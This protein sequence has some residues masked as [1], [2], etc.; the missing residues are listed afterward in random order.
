MTNHKYIVVAGANGDLGA[1]ICRE[2]LARNARV[3]AL[4]RPGANRNELASLKQDALEIFDVDFSSKEQLIA[5]VQ[6]AHCVVSALSGLESVIIDTQTR[7]LEAVEA[8][9]VKRFIPSDF[10]VDFREIPDGTNRNLELRKRFKK[11]LD[12]SRL[13][14]T[15][16]LNGAFSD[17]LTTVMPLILF[18]LKRVVYFQN[19]DQKM[20]FTTIDTTAAFTAA[21]AL[22]SDTPRYL[23]IAAD[24][25][26]SRD[27]AE[28]MTSITGTRYRLLNGGNLAMLRFYIR[29]AKFF[30]PQ[31]ND[32]YPAWQGMQYFHSLFSGVTKL[33][34][35]DNDRYSGIHWRTAR[36]VLTEWHK[37]NKGAAS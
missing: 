9:D 7:L 36:D 15:S 6:S 11:R 29:C 16:I 19:P 25:L 23:Y 10:A 33:K 20:D 37:N 35:I 8:S 34:Q 26:S 21:A 30:T 27:F 13:E 24:Q 32:L 18:K 17:M 12:Q 31:S 1:R 28:L 2:L 5:A 3:R 4:V 22:D 14:L